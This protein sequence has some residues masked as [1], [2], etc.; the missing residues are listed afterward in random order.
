MVKTGEVTSVGDTYAEVSGEIIDVGADRINEHGHC[1]ATSQN[2]TTSNHITQLGTRNE[3]GTFKSYLSG[4]SSNTLYYVKT[5]AI[6]NEGTVYGKQVSFTTEVIVSLPIVTTS[7]ITDITDTSASCGGNVTSD[8]G[9]GVIE[10]GVC[11]STSLNPTIADSYT[12]DGRGIGV[13]TSSLTG[14]SPDS[15]YYVR[16]FATNCCAAFGED[17]T[18]YGNQ[19][20]FKTELPDSIPG[21]KT[22][23]LTNITKTSASSGGN[24]IYDGGTDVTNRGVCWSTS[25][26]PTIADF[27]TTDGSGTGIFSSSLTDLSS[28]TK[29]YTRAYATNR[30]GT[31]YGD[32]VS[33]LAPKSLPDVTTLPVTENTCDLTCGGDVTDDGGSYV[34]EKGVCLSTSPEP[35]VADF[36]TSDGSG[37]G[38]FLRTF[39]LD[40]GTYYFRAYATNS[41]GTAYGNE[42]SI[43]YDSPWAFSPSVST[44]VVADITSTSATCGGNVTDDGGSTVYERGVCWSTSTHPTIEDYHTND[45]SGTGVFSSSLTG[46]SSNTTY[47]VRAYATNSPGACGDGVTTYGQEYVFET[48]GQ[49]GCGTITDYDGNEYSTVQIGNQCWMQGNLKVTHYSDGTIISLVEGTSE[50]DGL[51]ETDEAYCY[52]DN[53]TANRDVYGA[54]YTWAAAMDGAASSNANPSRIQGVCPDGWH[55]PSDAEWKQLEKYLGMSQAE[56][57]GTGYY[58]GTD[59]G[60]KLKETGTVQWDSPNTGATNSSGFAALP[61]GSRSRDGGFNG[62]GSGAVFWS[63]MEDISVLAWDRALHYGHSEV[64]RGSNYKNFGFSV[65]CLRDF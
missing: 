37:T 47:Y 41:D 38:I 44:S 62:M 11:W 60:G 50:W 51:I 1:W 10:R 40:D 24:V 61:G 7:S 30:I 56:A 39:Y 32:Q 12:T 20:S 18:A 27:F 16:A 4:L 54:L 31:A 63:S 64:L 13:F 52:Y 43:T 19:V 17:G 35:T 49:P 21:V 29:Y 48:S 65:R 59:E 26:N 55:L 34:I 9:I 2:P 14:L 45:G 3:S 5:Y 25:P 42:V 33:F 8:G 23:P 28:N 53:S 57:D 36:H 22:S 58:R 6:N 15:I 46:L